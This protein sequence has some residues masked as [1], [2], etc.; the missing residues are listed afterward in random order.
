MKITTL[1]EYQALRQGA[2][3]LESDYYGDKVLRLRD[4]SILKMFR[5]KRIFS[6]AALY[7]YAQRFAD[8]AQ[9]LQKLGILSPHV[10][11]VMRIVALER[12]AV[13]Y[14]PLLGVTLRELARQGLSA[15]EKQRL[16]EKLTHF[17]AHLHD[18]GIYFR[19]LHLGNVVCTPDDEL[20]LIDIADLKCHRR[21]LGKYLRT[22]N[23][24]RLKEM[25]G[26]SDWLDY[27]AVLTTTKAESSLPPAVQKC[28]EP[29]K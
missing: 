7:P 10:I 23:V 24:R 21:P 14:Q 20:G 29:Q 8:N 13:H 22:R 12:D 16:R 4:G 15:S 27:D 28:H 5:R 1:E 11:D 9:A 25:P 19:S 6:S 26:E 2:L 3:V 18:C 17:V